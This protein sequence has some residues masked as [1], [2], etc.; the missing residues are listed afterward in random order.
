MVKG[1][2]DDSFCVGLQSFMSLTVVT[3]LIYVP[4]VFGKGISPALCLDGKW[5]HIC[6]LKDNKNDIL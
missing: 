1:G 5:Y 3:P 6:C 4:G 2:V